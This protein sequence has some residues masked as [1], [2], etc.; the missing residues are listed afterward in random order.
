MDSFSELPNH[1]IAL[2]VQ[3]L[4]IEEQC[5]C[6]VV[7]KAF[8]SLNSQQQLGPILRI[9]PQQVS[10]RTHQEVVSRSKDVPDGPS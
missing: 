10:H 6:C 8:N 1:L 9:R 3:Q 4:P 2:M 5:K 7:S